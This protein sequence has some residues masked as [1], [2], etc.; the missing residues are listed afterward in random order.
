MYF[1]VTGCN[2]QQTIYIKID[3]QIKDRREKRKENMWHKGKVEKRERE[4]GEGK[5]GRRE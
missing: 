4:E 5:K 3:M 2:V 1:P